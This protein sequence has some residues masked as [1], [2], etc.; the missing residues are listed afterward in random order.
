MAGLNPFVVLSAGQLQV[1]GQARLV[2][3]LVIFNVVRLQ[4]PVAMGHHRMAVQNGDAPQHRTA[5]RLQPHRHILRRRR[6][7]HR[8]RILRLA[9]RV[10][11]CVAGRNRRAC[12]TCRRH[13]APAARRRARHRSHF[14]QRCRT[15]H[16]LRRKMSKTC[17][18][19]RDTYEE[20]DTPQ[21]LRMVEPAVNICRTHHSLR[22]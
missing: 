18:A 12:C 4:Y 5:I 1:P 11:Q 3:V 20:A 8:R 17:H 9:R 19:H 6:N 21:R 10:G 2:R 15:R 16:L 14:T 22:V 7:R 13:H